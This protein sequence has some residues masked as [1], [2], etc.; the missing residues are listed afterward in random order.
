MQHSPT[1]MFDTICIV[2]QCNKRSHFGIVT[3][4]FTR[5]F[6]QW[7]TAHIG[8]TRKFI[9]DA[10]IDMKK[11]TFSCI[12]LQWHRHGSTNVTPINFLS[13]LCKWRCHKTSAV[14]PEAALKTELFRVLL[15]SYQISVSLFIPHRV[16]HIHW[17][18]FRHTSFDFF[19]PDL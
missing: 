12:F 14:Y 19:R 9:K 6:R 5:F 11:V 18:L 1:K 2:C 13:F 4:Y 10:T 15:T 7:P 16:L 8:K 3:N 17:I